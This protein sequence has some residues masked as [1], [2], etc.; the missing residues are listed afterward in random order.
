MTTTGNNWQFD[1]NKMS[2][3]HDSVANGGLGIVD[4]W[5]NMGVRGEGVNVAVVDTGIIDH[6]DFTRNGISIIKGSHY[7]S[8]L[9][10]IID[11]NGHG[12][13]SASIIGATGNAKV[14]G[15]APAV[16]LY[17]IKSNQ[18][19][20]VDIEDF[21]SGLKLIQKEWPL[22]IISISYCFDKTNP[23]F[24]NYF[25]SIN[26][27]CF[28]LSALS[29]FSGNN[30]SINNCQYPASY[31]RVIPV[32]AMKKN[33]SDI[34]APCELIETQNK[35][36]WGF[37]GED[38]LVLNKDGNC[39]NAQQTSIATPFGCGVIAL[40]ISYM[41]KKN[42]PIVKRNM[43]KLQNLLIDTATTKDV[44]FDENNNKIT[45]KVQYISPFKAFTQFN[46]Y[47]K[48]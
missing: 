36:I 32:V 44:I 25:D 40:F 19:L 37:P 26:E 2:W 47:F 5:N 13:N 30:I 29:H 22:D 1:P 38:I 23:D 7:N 12:T 45:V 20:Y 14:F 46:N 6:N 3:A 28:V 10:S 9:S 42:I 24:E 16:N 48:N 34:L 35:S 21:F 39:E 18:R 31:H 11:T 17:I 33:L 27:N 4:L 41:K 43:D 15:I 8:E